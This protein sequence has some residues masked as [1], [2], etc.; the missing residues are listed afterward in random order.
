MAQMRFW[1]V[2]TLSVCLYSLLFWLYL[3]LRIIINHI[4]PFDRFIGFVPFF[5]FFNLGIFTFL[6]SF[7][8]CV[9]YLT[10]WGH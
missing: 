4:N 9:I 5:T 8:S 1:K 10:Y 7:V 6:L 3:V 2:L